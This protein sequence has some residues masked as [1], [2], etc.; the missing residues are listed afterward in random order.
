MKYSHNG[1][2]HINDIKVQSAVMTEIPGRCKKH[3]TRL[4]Y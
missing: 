2:N 1:K 3:Y 4:K